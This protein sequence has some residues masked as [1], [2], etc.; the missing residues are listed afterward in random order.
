MTLSEIFRWID[1]TPGQHHA[2]GRYQF[3]PSTLA[4]LVEAERVSMS[5]TFDAELQKQLAFRLM[6]DGGYRE[7]E[8]GSMSMSRFQDR[9]ARIWAGLPM[10]NGRSAYHGT[11]GN[12]ATISRAD[13][14]AAMRQI[15]S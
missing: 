14:D 11:A 7:F 5:R 6:L 1:D 4:Y 9:L 15:F 12:R 13:F 3:I 10:A 8:I 2:I